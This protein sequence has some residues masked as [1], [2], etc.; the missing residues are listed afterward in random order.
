M[1]IYFILYSDIDLYVLLFLSFWF[2]A[3]VP[4]PEQPNGDIHIQGTR[5]G[6]TSKWRF[7]NGQDMTYFQWNEAKAQ[8]DHRSGE[9]VLAMQ[10]VWGSLWHD[11]HDY[12]EIMFVCEIL[13]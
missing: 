9:N 3:T 12:I 13:L 5:V 4:D 8:P 1:N 11:T 7:D 10:K 6:N 2:V